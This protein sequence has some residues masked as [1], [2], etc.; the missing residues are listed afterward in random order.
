MD[1]GKDGMEELYTSPKI[2]IIKFNAKDVI[3]TSGCDYS[4]LTI[5]SPEVANELTGWTGLY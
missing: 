4:D 2:E 1:G 5:F 3:T